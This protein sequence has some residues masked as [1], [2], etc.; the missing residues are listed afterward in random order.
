MHLLAACEVSFSVC[1]SLALPGM[2]REQ[3]G[4]HIGRERD[5]AFEEDEWC[6]KCL[7]QSVR[8]WLC[9]RSL[10]RSLALA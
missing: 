3:D 7:D 5:L 2:T 10:E 4:R 6:P 1:S 9:W 8:P